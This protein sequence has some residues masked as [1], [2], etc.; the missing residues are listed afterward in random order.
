MLVGVPREIKVHESRV[1]LTPAGALALSSTGHQVLVEA[2]AGVAS[3]FADLDYLRAGASIVAHPEE[4]Y[5]QST[6]IVKVKEPQPIE[7]ARLSAR[8]TVFGYFH[9]AADRE[10]TETCVE[11][12]VTAL[13]YETLRRADGS[14]P[15]LNPMSAIAGRLSVQAGAHFLEKPRGGSGVLLGGVPGVLPGRV[16]VLGGGTVGS[17]A[18]QMAAGLGA[19]VV[20]CDVNGARL[21]RLARELPANVRGLLA[22]PSSIEEELTKADLVI[23]AVLVPGRRAPHLVSRAQLAIMKPGSVIVDVAIDQGGC[24]ESSRPTT[25]DDPIY[26][27][28]GILHYMVT[29]MPAAVP[30]T[31]T[32]ALTG[33]TL[34]Y[35]LELAQLGPEGFTALGPGHAAAL[36]LRDGAIT[37]PDAAA[38]FPDLPSR[39]S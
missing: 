12:G 24:F 16:L 28:N 1:G 7:V 2:G 19:D 9:F 4:L 25:H 10:L 17:N 8:Q 21:E 3:G 26:V 29:N 37:N 38:A 27:E 31:S 33:A 15:L 30:H 6:L 35:V 23:G 22:E 14:L 36:N 34:P 20:I 13:A 39:L 5:G 32:R 18:A 11:S